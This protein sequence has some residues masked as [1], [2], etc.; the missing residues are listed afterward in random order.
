MNNITFK[1][2]G[3]HSL[4]HSGWEERFDYNSRRHHFVNYQTNQSQWDDPRIAVYEEKQ[5]EVNYL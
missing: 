3:Y 1:S 5:R 2:K 4:V